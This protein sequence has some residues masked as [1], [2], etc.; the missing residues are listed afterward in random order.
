MNLSDDYQYI[1]DFYELLNKAEEEARSLRSFPKIHGYIKV[2]ENLHRVVV[3]NF[4]WK[5]K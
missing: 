5:T 4:L 3:E 1:I 2:M